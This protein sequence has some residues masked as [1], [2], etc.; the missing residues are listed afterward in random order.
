M[1]FE[2]VKEALIEQLKPLLM[3][4]EFPD[5]F[6]QL[7]STES[8]TNRFL[9]KMELKR[10]ASA[11]NRVI[12]LRDKTD[13]PC[14]PVVF[15]KQTHLLDAPSKQAFLESINR[16]QQH[17]TIG[18]YEE[19][20]DAHKQRLRNKKQSPLKTDDQNDYVVPGVIL[21]NYFN[22]IEERMN[23][24]INITAF[25]SGKNELKGSTLD[26]S[27][28]G[29]R[30]RLPKKHGFDT[31]QS[32]LVKLIEINEEYYYKDLH[33]GIEYQI[34]DVE[35]SDDH[36][37]IRLKRLSGSEDLS[38]ILAN[39]I[40]GFKYRYKVDVNEVYTNSLAL[41]YERHYLP[42]YR[43]LALFINAESNSVTH[44]LLGAEN[45]RIKNY[46]LNEKDVCQ[47]SKM[48]TP[49]RIQ[50]HNVDPENADHSLVYCFNHVVN[51][52]MYF[53]SASLF[54]LKR[55]D[56]QRLFFQ[57]GSQKESWRIFQIVAK[58]INHSLSYKTAILPGDER[59]YTPLIERELSQFSHVVNL[60]DLTHDDSKDD[61]KSWTSTD[62]ANQLKL[63]A[64]V[65]TTKND[66]KYVS[67]NFAERRQ[68]S[69]YSF[70]TQIDLTQTDSNKKNKSATG[71]SLDISTKGF[72]VTLEENCD[73]DLSKPINVSLP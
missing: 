23:Y 67:L 61:Y 45:Q 13:L 17:Y 39:L 15:K 63:F 56:L 41:G 46:F 16:Y 29:A 36:S 50:N 52:K 57:F 43:H 24:S 27:V 49:E 51:D 60:I 42:H 55:Q 47:L 54:E 69:R 4:P 65:K 40:K 34:V 31:T 12:D 5:F 20:F 28:S 7:T 38:Q 53:Y 19:V 66:I 59:H 71:M 3:E 25:Q 8:S 35:A 6:D 72:Q 32:I 11:C 10:L 1:S 14:E 26:L 58:P 21:G 68:E 37:I 2:D 64:Q 9:L 62:N 70:K 30:I 18:V 44:G 33:Q 73:F 22:R 48:L